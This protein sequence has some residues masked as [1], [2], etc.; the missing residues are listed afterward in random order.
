MNLLTEKEKVICELVYLKD[1]CLRLGDPGV[2]QN[3]FQAFERIL[4]Y[5]E[6]LE[7]QTK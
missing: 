3:A 2:T 4:K 7:S 6:F 5:I 1:T